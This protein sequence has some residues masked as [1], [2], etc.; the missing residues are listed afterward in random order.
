MTATAIRPALI[1]GA[2][3]LCTTLTACNPYSPGQRAVGGGLIGA[4]TGA[5]VA[6]ATRG[7]A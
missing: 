3:V 4:G 2:V 1:A 5:A 6:G 7:N